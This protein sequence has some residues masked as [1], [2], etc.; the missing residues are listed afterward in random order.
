MSGVA[1][2]LR[3][4]WLLM[5]AVAIVGMAGSAELLAR[6]AGGSPAAFLFSR[7]FRDR[8]TDWDVT[9]AVTESGQR[10]TCP[11]PGVVKA[12]RKFVVIGDSFVFGQGVPDCR[13]VTSRLASLV[14]DG[15]F[16]NFGI[17]GVGIEIYRQVVDDM[18]GPDVTDVLIL[19]Y[20]NDVSESINAKSFL[21]RL[22]DKSSAFA[23]LRKLKRTILDPYLHPEFPDWRAMEKAEPPW[24]N[25]AFVLAR[26]PDYF[27]RV[28]EPGDL[29]IA[30]FRSEFSGLVR[31][32]EK[33]VPRNRIW[34]AVVPEATTVSPAIRRWVAELGGALPAFDVAGSGYRAI[35]ALA[36]EAGVNFV[37]LFP[38]FRCRGDDAYFPHDL[39]WS[40]VG[41]QL[42]A[43]II[44]EA[45]GASSGTQI[46]ERGR[47][48]Q[49]VNPAQLPKPSP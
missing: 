11:D 13:D 24:N 23:L 28:A 44:A 5:L 10:V 39:H 34:M 22:A 41:H 46:V 30:R 49:S 6:L 47:A 38:S 1:T 2:R 8:Q 32:I 4:F 27:A 37:D 36:R 31:S 19:F 48:C 16:V 18:L 26:E 15:A 3:V 9:Y 14:S 33:I 45:L 7:P 12:R 42:A 21:G 20:G 43:E 29:N 25:I 40:E 17:G 35:E